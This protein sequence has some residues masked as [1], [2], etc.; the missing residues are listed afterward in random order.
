MVKHNSD[1]FTPDTWPAFFA[2]M[3]AFHR[4]HGSKAFAACL[5]ES[6]HAA[7]A[8]AS[9]APVQKYHTHAYFLWTDGIGYRADSVDALRVEGVLPRVDKYMVGAASRAPRL[10][11]L[12]GLW[13]VS[14]KKAGTRSSHTNFHP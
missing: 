2:H 9:A 1:A 11:A 7:A 4:K 3:E 13:Y 8:T 12:H 10:A 6:L 14:V 5:E